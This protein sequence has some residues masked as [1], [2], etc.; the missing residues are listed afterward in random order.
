MTRRRF[1]KGYVKLF[2]KKR[3]RIWKGK[4]RMDVRLPEGQVCRKQSWVR[5]GTLEELPTRRRAE[6]KMS[7]FLQKINSP[8]Y[9]PTTTETVRGFVENKYMKLFLPTKKKSTQRYYLELLRVHILGHYGTMR[10]DD[11]EEENIQAFLNQKASSG[12]AWNYVRN[13]K[14]VL[15]SVFSVARRYGDLTRRNPVTG[16]QLPPRPPR[17]KKTLPTDRELN[18]IEAGLPEPYA[19]LFWLTYITGLRIGEVTA[20]RWRHVDWERRCIW[21]EEAFSEGDFHTPEVPHTEPTHLSEEAMRRLWTFREQ[22]KPRS[23]DEWV[24]V[25]RKGTAPIRYHNVLRRHLKPLAQ[26]LGINI[27]WHLLRHWN[28][29]MMHDEGVPLKVAQARLGHARA[30]TTMEHYTHLTQHAME[31]AAETISRRLRHLN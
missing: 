13:F 14:I 6:R 18:L 1:Q 11:V 24:F 4:Y 8:D 9:R 20:L 5:L 10:L 21:V 30:E 23:E 25:N 19:T 17:R 22:R 26:K 28:A 31:E 15:S 27:T 3:Q 7:E 12:L 2:G 29:T 16:A